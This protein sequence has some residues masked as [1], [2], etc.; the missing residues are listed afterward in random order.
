MSGPIQCSN[1]FFVI[2]TSSFGCLI[3]LKTYTSQPFSLSPTYIKVLFLYCNYTSQNDDDSNLI[4]AVNRRKTD[5][6]MPKR[7]KTNN[8]SQ[9]LNRKKN[10]DNTN[11]HLKARN[12]G[13]CSGRVASSW[14]MMGVR[15]VSH[16]FGDTYWV[17][18]EWMDCDNHR[19][20]TV[21]LRD[22][23]VY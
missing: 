9:T 3:F 19:N 10:L 11:I 22:T 21:F 14:S 15:H 5:N 1:Q 13:K 23:C 17:K 16:V 4:Q 8:G 12:K 7:R 20:I 2:F 18:K 6:M